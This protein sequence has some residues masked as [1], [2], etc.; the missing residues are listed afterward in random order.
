VSEEPVS[1]FIAHR[2]SF[3]ARIASVT[4]RVLF[5]LLVFA[6]AACG[7]RGDPRP[8]VPVIPA[9][10][11]DL[12]VTQRAGRVLLSWSYPALTTAGR[13]LTDI[14][15]ISIHRYV[16]PLPVAPGG[17]DPK[18]LIPGDVDTTEP[19][20]L[21]LFSKIP[22]IPQAQFEKLSTRLDS[23]EK[24]NLADATAGTRLLFT[25]TPPFRS[26]DGRPV[27]LTYAVV[28]EGG[29]ARSQAS[30]LAIIVPLPV[31]VAPPGVTA[32]AKAEGVTVSWTAPATSVTGDAGPVVTGYNIYRA[33]P[34]TELGDLATPINT[35]PVKGTT[36]LDTPAYGEHEYRVAA[37]A[38][39]GPP[40][41]QSDLS[42]PAR[43]TFR[44]LV[45][46]PAPASATVLLETK[47][48][49]LL[50]D[51]VDAPDLA[52]Y[53]VHRI[54]GKYRLKLTPTPV[55][56]TNFLDISIDIGIGYSY[57]I[58]AIDTSGNES[59]PVKTETVIVPKTP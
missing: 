16:E 34:G 53:D 10:T 5:V 22:T 11:T 49:R 23:I 28:T 26:T 15:R 59:Q 1:K 14:R 54:E 4:R 25:D 31:G 44:D 52:G 9:A 39:T 57:E 48:V 2:S 12:V 37:V 42:A 17:R 51:A 55:K 19:Q 35:A 50:W 13:S 46:P 58:T 56:E 7:K 27:R 18:T 40:S 36:Y 38:T 33:A 24:A 21:I 30:N 43:V 3:I 45:P 8:P 41:I 6:I 32:A 29:T 20:P 47:L